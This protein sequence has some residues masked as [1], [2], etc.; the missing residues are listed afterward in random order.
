MYVRIAIF[1]SFSLF[2]SIAVVLHS[3]RARVDENVLQHL[4]P[5][6]DHDVAHAHAMAVDV[7]RQS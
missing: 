4:K 7:P 2:E 3:K 1:F 5:F 6:N